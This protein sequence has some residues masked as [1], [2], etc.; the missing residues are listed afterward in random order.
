MSKI[1]EFL[2]KTR[3]VVLIF[4][5]L[6]WG[7]AWHYTVSTE[8]MEG[9]VQ[10]AS[11]HLC[12]W[13]ILLWWAGH[14]LGAGIHHHMLWV[15]W[16]LCLGA[17]PRSLWRES[18]HR[19]SGW[20]TTDWLCSPG[21]VTGLYGRGLIHKKM[22]EKNKGFAIYLEPTVSLKGISVKIDG[23]VIKLSLFKVP[24]HNFVIFIYSPNKNISL[25]QL[26]NPLLCVPERP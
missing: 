8:A 10:K 23:L 26:L 6:W 11:C 9:E 21:W 1:P 5:L 18:I 12:N 24:L 7:S 19:F 20:P 15:L 2:I 25:D 17:G 16:R 4:F 3:S 14:L 13:T 22:L